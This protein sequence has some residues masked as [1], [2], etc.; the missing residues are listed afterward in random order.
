MKLSMMLT[1]NAKVIHIK[2]AITFIKTLASFH[3]HQYQILV[4]STKELHSIV[5]QLLFRTAVEDLIAD[6]SLGYFLNRLIKRNHF[7]YWL[8]K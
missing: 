8:M 3:I 2:V 6:S 1:F 5:S 4:V 7:V